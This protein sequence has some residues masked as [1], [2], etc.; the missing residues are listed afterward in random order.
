[1]EFDLVNFGPGLAEGIGTS[2]ARSTRTHNRIGFVCEGTM[3][4]HGD[5]NALSRTTSSIWCGAHDIV[6]R[7][8]LTFSCC[9]A[10]E[11]GGQIKT[12]LAPTPPVVSEGLDFSQPPKFPVAW[13]VFDV[14][15]AK[16]QSRRRIQANSQRRDRDVYFER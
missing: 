8:G 16:R 10:P 5:D 2:L 4:W 6:D 7:L 1:M 15:R 14:S 13:G 12:M 11:K 3:T 9:A